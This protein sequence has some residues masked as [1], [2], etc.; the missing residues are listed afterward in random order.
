MS[1]FLEEK[2][3]IRDKILDTASEIFAEKGYQNTTVRDICQ[4]ADTYQLSINY[5]F[6]NKENLFKEVLLNTYQN[7][8]ET[9]LIEKTKFF[10]P[11]K[12]LEEVIRIRVKSVFS[13]GKEGLYF[14]I[15]A[16]E[17]SSNYNFIVEIMNDPLLEY[18]KFTRGIFDKLSEHKLDEF[19]LNYCVYLL[20]SHISALTLHEKAR[21]ILF[22][23]CK[24][25]EEQFEMFIQYIKKFICAGVERMKAD[26]TAK[27][28][29]K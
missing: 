7:T 12:Q 13:D 10:P 2:E 27:E 22:D 1:E 6:G 23:T 20:M 29:V 9:D 24:P 19:G 4:K 11:E 15:I 28:E 25:D 8:H 17:I 14:K 21:L 3:N 26:K 16:K 18:L 5:H